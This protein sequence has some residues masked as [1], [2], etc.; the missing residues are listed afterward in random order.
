[1]N[2]IKIKGAETSVVTLLNLLLPGLGM[3]T[4]L[5]SELLPVLLEQIE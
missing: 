5:I 4:P 2:Y 1:M 3:V